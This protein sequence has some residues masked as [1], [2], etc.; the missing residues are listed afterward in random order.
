MTHE[1]AEALVAESVARLWSPE[2]SEA[3]AYLTGP[4]R[5][6]TPETIR[7]AR[8]GVVLDP[9]P[10]PGRPRGIVV[11]WLCGDRPTLV[12]IRQPDWRKPKYHEGYRDRARH[13][14]IYP[15]PA[16]I[17]PGRPLVIVEG[18]FDSLCLGQELG[19]LA[20][21]VTL[22]SA[23]ARPDPAILGRMLSAAPWFVATDADPAGDKAADGW[24]ASA[25][26]VRPPGSFKDWTEAKAGRVDLHRWWR[27][28]L[29]GNPT[30]PLHT[31]D[32]LAKWRW[33]PA[34][35]DPTPGIF[36]P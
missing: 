24:P 26:R 1:A 33:G 31:W 36:R 35:D 16:T 3:L 9:L 21:V 20:A 11:P 14:G 7:A 25:R 10:I 32:E 29:T 30:P 19:A 34:V 23:S 22:G 15:D 12:K 27:D 5:C 6:L 13:S 28:I 8:L 2:G 4:E 18:E 17:R